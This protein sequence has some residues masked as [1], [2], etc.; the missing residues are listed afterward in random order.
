MIEIRNPTNNEIEGL[1]N[2]KKSFSDFLEKRFREFVKNNRDLVY[3]AFEENIVG[4][5]HG[6]LWRENIGAIREV[7]AIKKDIEISLVEKMEETFKKK[8]CKK[9]RVWIDENQ[10]ILKNY[11][12]KNGYSITTELLSFE[13]SDL[14]YPTKGN[15]DVTVKKFEEKYIDELIKIEETSFSPEWQTSKESFLNTPKNIKFD[16]AFYN[17]KVVGYL[18]V[19][20]GERIG[21]YGKVAVSPD[22]RC[23]G[24]G[25]RLTY[26][27]I[28][29]FKEKNVRKIFLRTPKDDI[30]AQNLYKKFGFKEVSKEYDLMKKV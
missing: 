25:S 5:S 27:A 12:M 7:R 3:I 21:H 8:N 15:P 17:K 29:F 24:I 1:I 2:F 22:F 19:S 23:M 16:L 28:K 30:P 9:V 26:E 11:L 4:F 6:Y 10:E 14:D 18:I 20:A 13:K